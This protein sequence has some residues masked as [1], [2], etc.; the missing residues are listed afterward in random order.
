MI[1]SLQATKSR[2]NVES[3][4][5]Q[6]RVRNNHY[7]A[8]KSWIALNSKEEDLTE[9]SEYPHPYEPYFHFKKNYDHYLK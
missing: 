8:E 5:P 1:F 6:S 4:H 3:V 7:D 9:P 2:N